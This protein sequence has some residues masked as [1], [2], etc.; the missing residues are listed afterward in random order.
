MNM[1][2][3]YNITECYLHEY[4]MQHYQLYNNKNPLIQT[5]VT[6][7]FQTSTVRKGGVRLYYY[8]CLSFV[9]LL[10]FPDGNVKRSLFFLMELLVRM[11]V[12]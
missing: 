8:F 4:A 11:T 3:V 9:I 6:R 5:S 12:G 7:K 10:F 2:N 1:L